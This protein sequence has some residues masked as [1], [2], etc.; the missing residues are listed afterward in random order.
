MSAVSVN[1]RRYSG[2]KCE[3]VTETWKLDCFWVAWVIAIWIFQ[4][5]RS[6]VDSR[7]SVNQ[8]VVNNHSACPHCRR[9][10][11][12][13]VAEKWDCRTKVRL[14]QKSATVAEFRR[15]LAVFGDS[16]T[17]LRQFHFSATVWIGLYTDVIYSSFATLGTQCTGS[18][19]TTFCCWHDLLSN[20]HICSYIHMCNW[21]N[22]KLWQK[23]WK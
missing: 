20:W 18:K 5:M 1:C 9:K 16:L 12:Q 3:T 19:G 8:L 6:V 22:V 15:C 4:N 23:M 7:S 14:S 11:R 17:F 21:E 13:F 2:T 10:V